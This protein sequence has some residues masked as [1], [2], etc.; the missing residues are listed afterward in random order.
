MGE[1]VGR[2]FGPNAEELGGAVNASRDVTGTD[3][4]L[5]LYGYIAG[6]Q[7]APS[8]TLGSAGLLAGNRRDFTAMTA[9]LQEDDG[10]A[11]VERIANGWSVSV[12]GRTVE[13][14]DDPD[15]GSDPQFP[16]SYFRSLGDLGDGVAYFWRQADG[17]WRNPEFSHFDVKGWAF[18]NGT[19]KGT[20]FP[21]PITTSSMATGHPI[22][23]CQPVERQPMTA[24][25]KR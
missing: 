23:Q 24:G 15:Y 12:G 17:S 25:W 20:S 13:L 21:A 16:Y 1:I 10:M 4:D 14:R 11:T 6:R 8:K 2:F 22:P 9:E 5:N 19:L 3:D 18:L 7:L